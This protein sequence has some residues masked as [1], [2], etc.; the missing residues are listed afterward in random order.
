MSSNNLE[1]MSHSHTL[2]GIRPLD[3]LDH[4]Q[5]PSIPPITSSPSQDD[6]PVEVGII[7]NR[8]VATSVKVSTGKRRKVVIN[9]NS[10]PLAPR[11]TRFG[12]ENSKNHN[13]VKSKT[14]KPVS[15]E[16]IKT[17]TKATRQK[18]LHETFELHDTK[19]RELFHLTKFVTLVDYD[20]KVAKQDESEV[21]KEVLLSHVSTN[22]NSIKFKQPYE[23]WQKA[24]DAKSGGR[25]RST[26]H[27]IST[28]KD[29]LG[30]AFTT[31]PSLKSITST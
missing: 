16:K 11:K 3:V 12:S 30:S 19:V 17:V 24:A 7:S 22:A 27:A 15:A 31:H 28:Q 18:R 21:F 29:A 14:H 5:S 8:E 6:Y 25:V 4:D 10:T 9:G 20:A 23:L 26:R 2:N 1:T 13:P